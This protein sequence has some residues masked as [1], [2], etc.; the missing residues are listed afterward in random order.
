MP[1]NLLRFTIG[2]MVFQVLFWTMVPMLAHHAPPLDATEMYS[3]SLSFQWGFYK[4]PPMPAWIVSVVQMVVGK[5]MLSLFLCASMA[6][7]AS[8]YCVAWLANRFL[9]EKEASV[10]VFLYALTIYCNLWSTDFNHNQIQMPF[11]ALSIICLVMCLDTGSKKWAILLGVVMGLNALSKYTAAFIMPSAIALL[12]LS[13]HWRKHFNITQLS[14]ASITFL[15]IFAPH[16]FWL[17]QN[18][19]MPFHYVNER[20]DEMKNTNNLLDLADYIG[21]I[22]L[23][24]LCLILVCLFLL[25]KKSLE[26]NMTKNNQIFIWILGIGPVLTTIVLGLFVPL[27]HRWVI[28][29]LPMITI[30]FAMLMKGR[31]TYLYNKKAFTFFVVLQIL[32]GLAYI[33]KDKINPNQSARGNYPAPELAQA[34]YGKWH[35]L[36]SDRSFKIV[37]G[38]EWEAGVVSLF[39]PDKTYVYTHADSVITPWI[40]EKNANDCGMVMLNPS[41][42]DLERF[43]LA[44]IQEPIEVKSSITNSEAVINY[45]INPP[46]GKCLLK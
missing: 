26:S 40:S 43:P 32:L 7:S 27:Y 2:L 28:P 9:S 45:A 42:S 21:N 8:Y 41:T 1:K 11:W 31:F 23:A 46:Q 18:D 10:A 24:H 30:V 33:Y 5:N 20:F 38:G 25:R 19:F 36:Y 17:T 13:P 34:I 16:V 37:S 6:I 4:H 14:I 39:S 29:M 3:W 22:L 12:I 35:T 44:K 15:A